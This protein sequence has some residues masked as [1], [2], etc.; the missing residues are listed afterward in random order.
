MLLLKLFITYS[1]VFFS[2]C[3][4]EMTDWFVLKTTKQP[5]LHCFAFLPHTYHHICWFD[6]R[7][8]LFCSPTKTAPLRSQT[9]AKPLSIC[10]SPLQLAD[11]HVL[12]QPSSS[13]AGRVHSSYVAASM[14]PSP[15]PSCEPKV[16]EKT[17]MD[18]HLERRWVLRNETSQRGKCCV[19][20]CVCGWDCSWK[21]S[22][23]S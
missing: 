5:N 16:N 23:C 14:K 8:M 19:C 17:I 20:V 3:K 9:R 4:P 10:A 18:D 11:F 15:S 2:V 22:M 13:D 6:V 12:S 1:L 7:D 21:S